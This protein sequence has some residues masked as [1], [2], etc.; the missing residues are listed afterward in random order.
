M[1]SKVT[2]ET[3][4]TDSDATVK[5][6][7]FVSLLDT[8]AGHE[9]I[10]PELARRIESVRALLT[11]PETVERPFLTVLLRT[12]G[13]RLEPLKDALLCLAAQTD[14]DFE[15]VVL[16]HDALPEDAADVREIISRQPPAFL[17]RIRLIEV[18]GGT[19]AK[20]LNAGVLASTGH[21]VA[22]F[23][24]DDL[25]LANWVEE[26]HAASFLGDGRLL[27]S[28]VANQKV[29]PELWPQDHDG[30][31]TL[32]WPAAEYPS[33]FHQLKHLLVNY[34]PFM[35]WAFPRSLFFSFGVRF[36]EELTVCEDWDVILRGS[37]LCGVDEIQTLTAIYRRWEGGESSYT[38]H[39]TASWQWSENRVID[40]INASVLTL[41]E[42]SM[43]EIRDMVVY[44]AALHDYRFLFKGNKLRLPLQLGWQAASPAV[45]IIVRVRNKIR[46][47]RQR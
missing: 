22:V 38:S 6:P 28:T 16:E 31:R 19:R 13:R 18:S 8:V 36:D 46:R 5:L 4:D 41:P 26:F 37:L 39:S 29:A 10:D 25:V 21:Y 23:D 17:E 12:Q 3:V 27:R 9:Y 45:R 33:Q 34:S 30:F 40:R 47:M 20:P 15:V 7:S 35:S 44:D 32:S 43:K 14:Q 42:G 1:D 11:V 24:D 2:T